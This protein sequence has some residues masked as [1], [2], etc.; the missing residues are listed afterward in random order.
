MKNET[1]ITFVQ[2]FEKHNN[3]FNQ[4]CQRTNGSR[5]TVD[6]DFLPVAISFSKEIAK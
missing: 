5:K 2:N 6:F 1:Y 3:R 4:R